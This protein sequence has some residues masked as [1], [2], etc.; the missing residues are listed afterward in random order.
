[1]I[2]EYKFVQVSVVKHEVFAIDGEDV[3]K[4]FLFIWEV[5]ANLGKEGWELVTI[6]YNPSP[7]SSMYVFKRWV[8]ATEEQ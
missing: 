7:N 6:T 4:P 3:G 8:A 2:W 5:A 1:M